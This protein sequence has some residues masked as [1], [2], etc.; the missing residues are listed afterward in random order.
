MEGEES[1]DRGPR[2]SDLHVRRDLT[3][4]ETG[5]FSSGDNSAPRPSEMSVCG[6]VYVC[7]CLFT[8]FFVCVCVYTFVFSFGCLCELCR[9]SSC[10]YVFVYVKG[11]CLSLF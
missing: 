5:K 6:D 3:L 2:G 10:I 8:F 9:Y 1:Y 7:L 11:L 4:A